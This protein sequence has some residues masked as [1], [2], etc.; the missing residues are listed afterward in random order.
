VGGRA[1]AAAPDRLTAG[2]WS[3]ATSSMRARSGTLRL[4][5]FHLGYEAELRPTLMEMGM[6]VACRPGA[7]FSAM[8]E[9]GAGAVGISKVRHRTAL[10]VNEEGTEASAATSVHVERGAPAPPFTMTVDRPFAC[11][12]RE[13]STGLL[14]FLGWVAEP[15]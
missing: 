4:P 6:E 8:F 2:A 12:I 3:R 13:R 9:R 10:D 11:A 14:A 5:R 15:E 1:L 7:D